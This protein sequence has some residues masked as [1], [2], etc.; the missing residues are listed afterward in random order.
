M[1]AASDYDLQPGMQL[2]YKD[3]TVVTL[4]RRKDFSRD[5]WPGWW[6][7]DNA[8]GLADFVLDDPDSGWTVVE[9]PITPISLPEGDA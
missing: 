8:G 4:D 7:R 1:S 3:G 9:P 6:L 2:R 5:G